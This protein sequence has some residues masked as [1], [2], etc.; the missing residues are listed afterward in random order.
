MVNLFSFGGRRACARRRARIAGTG[1]RRPDDAHRHAFGTRLGERDV[2]VK[3]IQRLM[4]HADIK[5]TLR[6]V[7][8]DEE[9]LRAAVELAAGKGTRIVPG[10]AAAGRRGMRKALKSVG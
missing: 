3:K 9:S 6:Y 5:M 1:A 7:H 10:E 8:P 2:N 4:G